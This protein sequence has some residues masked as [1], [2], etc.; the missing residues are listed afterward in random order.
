MWH[1]PS[2]IHWLRTRDSNSELWVMS[3]LCYH[4]TNPRYILVV[5]K[6]LEPL[7]GSYPIRLMRPTLHLYHNLVA[8]TGFEPA[9]WNN[10]LQNTRSAVCPGE[11]WTRGRLVTWRWFNDGFKNIR[12]RECPEGCSPG[13]IM[14]RNKEGKFK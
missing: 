12:A 13:R 2:Y 10:G 14:P 3:P 6:G 11:G 5:I 4:Y 8:G 9:L 7:T 1:D